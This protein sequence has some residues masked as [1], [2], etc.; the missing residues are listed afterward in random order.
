VVPGRRLGE[1]LR[2]I[3][4]HTIKLA[5]YVRSLG[6]HSFSTW[7]LHT[8][9]HTPRNCARPCRRTPRPQSTMN[10]GGYDGNGRADA[11]HVGEPAPAARS[12]IGRNTAS[13]PTLR[14]PLHPL[15]AKLPSARR[16]FY[17]SCWLNLLLLRAGAGGE[18][19][20][21]RTL[22]VAQNFG[23]LLLFSLRFLIIQHF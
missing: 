6:S 17:T 14:P 20:P 12:G 11:D 8:T 2:V 23:L 16:T 15:H 13:R 21:T 5:F 22:D 9:A 7:S 4:T 1:G 10:C 3:C 18:R 19:G